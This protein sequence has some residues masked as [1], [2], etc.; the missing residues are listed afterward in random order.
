PSAPSSVA[1]VAV[2][3]VSARAPRSSR[4]VASMP[5]PALPPRA[6]SSA[7]GATRKSSSTLAARPATTVA[8]RWVVERTRYITAPAHGQ[9]TMTQY[10]VDIRNISKRFE[11][12][13]AVRDLSLRVPEGAVYGLLGPNGAGKTTTIR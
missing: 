1:A 9:A 6:T 11:G 10:A 2:A 4:S 5:T 12:H 3:A 7:I 13:V 8:T